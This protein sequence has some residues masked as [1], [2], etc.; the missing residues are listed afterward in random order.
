MK[1]FIADEHI[2]AKSIRLLKESGYDVLSIGEDFPTLKDI[3]VLALANQENRILITCDSDFGDLIFR[4]GQK[5]ET[6]VVYLRIGPFKSNEPG[7]MILRYLSVNENYFLGHFSV[8]D[9]G[10][11]RQIHL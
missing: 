8:V 3:D 1:S 4:Q 6:G 10:R 11:I 7:E 5:C 9:R 2:P